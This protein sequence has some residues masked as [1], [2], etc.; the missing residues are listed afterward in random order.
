MILFSKY[1]KKKKKKNVDKL[2]DKNKGYIHRKKKRKG[3][4]INSKIK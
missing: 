4:V 2:N 1:M 3:K